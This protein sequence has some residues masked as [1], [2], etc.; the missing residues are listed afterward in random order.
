MSGICIGLGLGPFP[1]QVIGIG[2]CLCRVCGL[3]HDLSI[4]LDL[5][6]CFGLVF[7]PALGHAL[8]I[9]LGMPLEFSRMC[10]FVMGVHRCHVRG[11]ILAVVFGLVVIT[12]IGIG[13]VLWPYYM[14]CALSCV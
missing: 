4:F 8:G 6:I 9:A 3:G 2:I 12:V 13:T 5:N 14:Y 10:E 1:G 7:G 11:V